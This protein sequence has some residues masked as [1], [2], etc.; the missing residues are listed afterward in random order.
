MSL[1]K[2]L[3]YQIVKHAVA[4]AVSRGSTVFAR[5]TKLV[6]NAMQLV[7]GPADAEKAPASMGRPLEAST[8]LRWLMTEHYF[9]GRYAEGAVP[10]AWVTSGAP[11]EI[12]R[13]FGFHTFYPENHAALCGVQREAVDLSGV[14]EK[15]GYSIDLCSYARTDIGSVL[16][17]RT[18]VGKVPRPDLLVACT[19]ICQTVLLWYRVLQQEFKV[20]LVIVDTPFI[21]EDA[22]EHD[23][24]YVR[25]GLEDL[26]AACES[27]TGTRMDQERF[28]ET[29]LEAKEATNLWGRCMATNEARPAPWT[30]VD[31]FFHMAPIVSMRGEPGTTS[32]YRQLLGELEGRVAS[33]VGASTNERHRV[34]W[35]NLPVWYWL[36]GMSTMLNETGTALVAA[37]YTNAWAETT[38]HLGTDDPL[39]GMVQ[40]YTYVIL[41]RGI[42][43]R[44]ELMKDLVER[45]RCD[46][47]ILHSDRSCK[48]Y[49]VGQYELARRLREEAGVKALV[50]EADHSDPRVAPEEQLTERLRTFL[51]S[52]DQ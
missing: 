21:Y 20:P 18:P 2:S 37:T 14:A 27:V 6:R 25:K 43:H 49:S 47:V 44:L 13:T 24:A 29:L 16:S 31:Q 5:T 10:V 32:Y 50:L 51:E 39:G 9:A 30:A 28:E 52:L 35:D 45:Y 33:G 22:R 17:G 4:P 15:R 36:R 34:L 48:P 46:S 19:N 23:L 1:T 11:V 7:S 12:L 3:Q 8:R 40:A 38:S 41:N 26:I 42:R